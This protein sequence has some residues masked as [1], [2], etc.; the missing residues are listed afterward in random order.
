MERKTVRPPFRLLLA[1]AALLVGL[2]LAPAGQDAGAADRGTSIVGPIAADVLRVVDGDTLTVRAHIWIGHEVET[3]V[4]LTGI[5]T[6]ELR[7][8]CPEEREKAREARA[9]L[10]R[11]VGEDPVMLMDIQSDK[12]GG[13][14]LAR[15]RNAAGADLAQS[16]IRAGL[17][18]PYKGDRRGVWCAG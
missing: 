14:V 11:L 7:A 2:S 3:S 5:D 4:R 6:P 1:L 9:F 16:L 12:Y 13:R 8:R 15:V 18:R 17:A 10:L